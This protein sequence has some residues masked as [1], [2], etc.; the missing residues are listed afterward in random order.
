MNPLVAPDMSLPLG[1]SKY[2]PDLVNSSGPPVFRNSFDG[3]SFDNSHMS[4]Y[5][6]R[7]HRSMTPNIPPNSRTS[8]SGS[9]SL[10]MKPTRFH[11]YS[12]PLSTQAAPQ[13]AMKPISLQ[14]AA[15][16]DPAAFRTD[17]QPFSGDVA[18]RQEIHGLGLGNFQSQSNDAHLAG[19]ADQDF[20]NLSANLY[21]D[22]D[23]S[24][25]TNDP[26]SDQT[27]PWENV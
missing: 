18:G 9:P 2:F 4:Q 24:Q 12:V 22:I 8:L 6:D 27:L 16:L 7:R 11:P 17:Y 23:F 1:A 21:K 19:R 10:F 3:S 14:R 13:T 25:A 26:D 5:L 15:S 20:L